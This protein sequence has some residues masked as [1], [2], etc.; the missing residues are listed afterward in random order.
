MKCCNAEM[1]RTTEKEKIGDTK[2]VWIT[3]SCSRCGAK[4]TGRELPKPQ[5]SMEDL[6]AMLEGGWP[7]C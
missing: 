6:D 4:E 1:A 2:V 3:Y 7:I 5:F